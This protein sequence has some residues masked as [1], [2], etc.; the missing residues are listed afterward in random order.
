[1]NLQYPQLINCQVCPQNCGVNRYETTGFCKAGFNLKINLAQLH[2][3]E[4]PV[5]SGSNGSGTIFFSYC[6]LRCVFCQ[7]YS[8]SHL[9]WGTYYNEEDCAQI[10]LKL[11]EAGAH[12]INLVSPTQYTPQLVK[13]ITIARENGLSIPVLW[14]SN[15]YENV[16]T[17]QSLAGLVDIYLPD[18]KYAHSFYSKKYSSAKDYPEIAIRALEEMF[19]QVGHL[20]L[21]SEGI[22]K[23][24]ILVRHLV[25]PNH[26]SGTKKVLYILYE[27]FGPELALSLMAQYYPTGKANEFPELNRSLKKEEYEEA[28]E[29]AEALGFKTLYLQKI[30]SS[31]EWTPDFQPHNEVFNERNLHFQGKKK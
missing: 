11:Q 20:Q 21:D 19:R 27:H 16:F 15:G 12:N 30:Y 4:E 3:G 13:T 10:M 17:L 8:I 24:G 9:G 2:H 28:V 25:L 22:A 7:N 14:N 1:M 31:P 18:F 29:T 26:L 23:K 6:N 5:F